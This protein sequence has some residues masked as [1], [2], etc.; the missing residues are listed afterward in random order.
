MKEER[1]V[2]DL[3]R[4]EETILLVPA[5]QSL[6]AEGIA[7]TGPTIALDGAMLERLGDVFRRHGL[8]YHGRHARSV[9]AARAPLRRIGVDAALMI[10]EGGASEEEA[11]AH[12]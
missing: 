9:H 3:G 10:H 7:E 1:L 12:V 8:E 5:P 6:L 4:L 2:R 11:Q